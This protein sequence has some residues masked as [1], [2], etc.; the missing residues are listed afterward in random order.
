MVKTLPW[1]FFLSGNFHA[2]ACQMTTNFTQVNE[3]KLAVSF[4]GEDTKRHK[5]KGLLK[6]MWKQLN[7]ESSREKWTYKKSESVSLHRRDD[8]R[9]LL[10]W[11]PKDLLSW[12][13]PAI[14][15]VMPK[16][17]KKRNLTCCKISSYSSAC[18]HYIA[19]LWYSWHSSFLAFK[20]AT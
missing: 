6:I 9:L 16:K 7:K 20:E 8:I 18:F 3:Q 2:C 14:N 17:K 1:N 5:E 11:K 19:I 12:T 15:N 4:Q 10:Y 13:K